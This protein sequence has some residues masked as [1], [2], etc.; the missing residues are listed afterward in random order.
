MSML[1]SCQ[2]RNGRRDLTI[3]R[4]CMRSQGKRFGMVSSAWRTC[5]EA[6]VRP[7]FMNTWLR[8]PRTKL[9]MLNLGMIDFLSMA[10]IRTNLVQAA[11]TK[12][13]IATKSP[14]RRRAL[15]K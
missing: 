4:L 15:N 14:H 8:Q 13:I 7:A 9:V 12:D 11:T 6:E 2:I 10:L 3:I 5:S 1:F